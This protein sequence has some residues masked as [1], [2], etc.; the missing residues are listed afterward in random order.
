MQIQL[1]D[2]PQLE[3]RA[4]SAGFASVEDYVRHLIEQAG[5]EIS[6]NVSREVDAGPIRPDAISYEEWRQRLR[7]FVGKQPSTNPQ[8]DDSRENM[9][10]DRSS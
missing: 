4:S 9:Y 5:D 2:D 3:S 6:V 10:S 7:G 1:P 8:F